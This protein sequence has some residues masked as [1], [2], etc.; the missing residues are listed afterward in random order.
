MPQTDSK[1]SELLELIQYRDWGMSSHT[2]FYIESKTG[3]VVSPYFDSE[4][5]AKLWLYRQE[6]KFI[7]QRT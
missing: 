6:Q 7:S 3:V 5:D 1:V 4:E 2:Y